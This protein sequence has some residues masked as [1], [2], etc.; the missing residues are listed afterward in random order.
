MRMINLQ[1]KLFNLR[2]SARKSDKFVAFSSLSNVAKLM[3]SIVL[4]MD[5]VSILEYPQL[6]A[7]LKAVGWKTSTTWWLLQEL[8]LVFKAF[9]PNPRWV[10]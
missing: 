1:M 9:L 7:N 2:S 8:I 5:R 3:R 6:L 10:S 4:E